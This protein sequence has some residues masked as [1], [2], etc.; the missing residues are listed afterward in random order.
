MPSTVAVDEKTGRKF[1]L[2]D[3]DDLKP[4]EKVVFLLNLHGGGS[5]G[6]W[7]RAYFPAVDYKDQYRLVIATPS[8]ATKEP[9]RRWVGEADDDHLHNI[10]DHVAAKYGPD[11]IAAFWL[12]GHSQGGMTSQRLLRDDAFFQDRVDG[13]LSLSG[14]RLQPA[15]RAPGFSLPMPPGAPAN[16]MPRPQPGAAPNADFSHIFAVGEYEIA[17]LPET[18]DWAAKYG[19]GPRERRADVVDSKAGQIHDATRESYSTKGWGLKARPGTSQV[20]VYPG[21]RDGRVVADV[22]RLDKGH[23]EGLEPHVTEELVKLIVSARG[24]KIRGG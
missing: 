10:V 4:G 6:A 2:D 19:A 5:V 9:M 24:G 7:Q 17:A 20:Y 22:V 8:A 18:S 16:T 13:W 21:A 14:G 12:V 1:Y 3:P 11:N 23:T 15:E